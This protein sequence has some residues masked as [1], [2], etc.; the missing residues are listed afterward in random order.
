MSGTPDQGDDDTS[1]PGTRYQVLMLA[2]LNQTRW[3]RPSEPPLSTPGLAI[4]DRGTE[5][6][7]RAVDIGADSH[8][9]GRAHSR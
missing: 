1:R 2:A 5:S 8:R 4:S 9:R 3:T 7:D 6:L